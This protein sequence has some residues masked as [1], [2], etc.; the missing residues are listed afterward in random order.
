MVS[1]TRKTGK[2]D[3]RRSLGASRLAPDGAWAGPLRGPAIRKKNPAHIPAGKRQVRYE[4]LVKHAKPARW[5]MPSVDHSG[6]WPTLGGYRRPNNN[7]NNAHG[8]YHG[9]LA[10]FSTIRKCPKNQPGGC[11]RPCGGDCAHFQIDPTAT[12]PTI[13]HFWK[14]WVIFAHFWFTVWP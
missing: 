3:H 11:S 6:F 9:Y 5:S 10:D 12:E 1:K 2:M 7:I 13:G 4:W 8:L 14:F